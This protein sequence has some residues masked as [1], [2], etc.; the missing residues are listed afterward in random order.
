MYVTR[1]FRDLVDPHSTYHARCCGEWKSNTHAKQ[2]KKNKKI[3]SWI[4]L[5]HR[6]SGLVSAQQQNELNPNRKT[7][8]NHIRPTN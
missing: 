8:K 3:S 5:A 2:P 4:L 1:V 6:F 7:M